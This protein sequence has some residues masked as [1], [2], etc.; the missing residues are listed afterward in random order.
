MFA[1]TSDRFVESVG[2]ESYIQ[3]ENVE[4]AYNCQLLNIVVKK[5][6]RL[7]DPKFALTNFSLQGLLKKSNQG[8][9]T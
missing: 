3:L 9:L 5:K 2:N 7:R 8:T 4:D 1:A 6:P